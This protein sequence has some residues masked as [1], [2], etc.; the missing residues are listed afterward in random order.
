MI[1]NHKRKS[2]HVGEDGT[3]RTVLIWDTDSRPLNDELEEDRDPLAKTYNF[4]KALEV[5]DL[6]IEG[7]E[8][9]D[10]SRNPYDSKA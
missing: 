8:E 3:G 7:E 2:W 10:G 6:A 4:L 9:D 5:P 1:D